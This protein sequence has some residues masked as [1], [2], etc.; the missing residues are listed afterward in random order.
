MVSRRPFVS[1]VDS[2][3]PRVPGSRRTLCGPLSHRR[4]RAT[5]AGSLP[6]LDG[7]PVSTSVGRLSRAPRVSRLHTGGPVA[8]VDEPHGDNSVIRLSGHGEPSRTAAM[9]ASSW[10]MYEDRVPRC[11]TGRSGPMSMITRSSRCGWTKFIAVAVARLPMTRQ[12]ISHRSAAMLQRAE[13][14]IPDENARSACSH[15]STPDAPFGRVCHERC[16]LHLM[17][18]KARSGLAFTVYMVES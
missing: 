11:S 1:T 17:N 12:V 5:G 3:A 18:H 13:P 4:R 8:V 10:C 16:C 6:H 7:L 14:V 15:S 2:C 9:T